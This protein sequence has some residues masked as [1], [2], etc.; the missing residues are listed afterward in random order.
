MNIKEILRLDRHKDLKTV[1]DEAETPI[2]LT[3]SSDALIN[4]EQLDELGMELVD[5]ATSLE[6]KRSIL[7]E[8][9]VLGEKAITTASAALGATD[10]ET[11]L[12]AISVLKKSA[13]VDTVALFIKPLCD[14]KDIDVQIAATKAMQALPANEVKKSRTRAERKAATS[15]AAAISSKSFSER[16]R[17]LIALQYSSDSSAIRAAHILVEKKDALEAV[18]L[19]IL[20]QKD[21]DGCKKHIDQCLNSKDLEMVHIGLV[22][23]R[24]STRLKKRN[25]QKIISLLRSNNIRIAIEAA[26]S[27]ITLKLKDAKPVFIQWARSKNQVFV[28][29]GVLGLKALGVENATDALYDIA[30][31]AKPSIRAEAI[32]A[33]YQ[34]PTAMS[35]NLVITGVQANDTIVWDASLD[36]IARCDDAEIGNFAKS[37]WKA[38]RNLKTKK[39]LAIAMALCDIQDGL[40]DIISASKTPHFKLRLRAAQAL[41]HINHPLSVDALVDLLKDTNPSVVCISAIGLGQLNDPLSRGALI[42]ILQTQ[43]YRASAIYALTKIA[44]RQNFEQPKNEK[45]L[46]A[47]SNEMAISYIKEYKLQQA[48]PFKNSAVL[49]NPDTQKA[50]FY[51]KGNTVISGFKI[52]NIEKTQITLSRDE[53]KVTI[54]MN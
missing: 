21:M 53:L 48:M 5:G 13:Y 19:R 23:A 42:D 15:I 52:T 35:R 11:R 47:L 43:E 44:G 41:A 3:I 12:L 18:A 37:A 24:N 32:R 27:A 51:K 29:T 49:I 30:R 4:D 10:K 34:T 22:I 38:S 28:L 33:V 45:E 16:K 6:R 14:D 46:T 26:Q 7:E 36:L 9:A 2:S 50:V 20:M 1:D 40:R 39:R 17:G 8:L 54:K 31:N 25:L